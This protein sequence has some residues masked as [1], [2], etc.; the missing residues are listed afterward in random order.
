MPAPPSTRLG[1]HAPAGGDPADIPADLLRLRDQV[2][3]A[4]AVFA[5]G[6]DAT[7]PGA[8]IPGRVYFATDLREPYYDDGRTWRWL[9]VEETPHLVGTSGEPPFAAGWRSSPL[10]AVRFWKRGPRVHLYGYVFTTNT[11]TTGG[12]DVFTLPA[13]YRPSAP[14]R[15]AAVLPANTRTWIRVGAD[16]VVHAADGRSHI[17]IDTSFDVA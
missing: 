1:L 11:T 8:G 9:A 2:D 12:R 3:A 15:A 10:S 7:R 16:G 14:V 4:V 17:H 6:P 5:Q 13:G